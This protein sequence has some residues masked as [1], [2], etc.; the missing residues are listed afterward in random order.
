[1]LR[2]ILIGLAAWAS[3]A[4]PAVAQDHY[5]VGVTGAMTGPAAGSLAPAVEGVRLYVER[6]NAA[7]GI[8]GRK[9]ELILQ[10]DAAEPSKAAANVKK[11]ISQDNVILLINASL[12]STYAP[13]MAEI[14]RA[15][16]PVLYMGAVCPKDVLPPAADT[17]QFCSTGFAQGFDTRAVLGFIKEVAK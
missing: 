16:V 1:M 17:L 4:L 6:L 5:V 11:L 7:G 14:K 12:S 9:V 10:D 3:L 13:M 8:N 15:K 2:R